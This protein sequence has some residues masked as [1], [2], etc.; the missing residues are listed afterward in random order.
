MLSFDEPDLLYDV[1]DHDESDS[2]SSGTCAFP[3]H[4]DESVGRVGDSAGHVTVPL[5]MFVACV[6]AFFFNRNRG[7]WSRCSDSCALTKRSQI[8]RPSTHRNLLSPKILIFLPSFN[9]SF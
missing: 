1:S 8:K 9:I 5:V 2:G 4:F 7:N 6:L 3:F